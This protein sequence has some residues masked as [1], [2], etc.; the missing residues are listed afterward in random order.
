M[1]LARGTLRLGVF[2]PD[3]A[4]PTCKLVRLAPGVLALVVAY[5][6][7]PSSHT[8]AFKGISILLGVLLSIGSSSA[9][10][11]IVAGCTIT[12]RRAFREG[13]RVRI[14][15]VLGDV[16][17]VRL[18]VTHLRTPKHEEVTIPNAQILG[19][20][21]VNCG[22]LAKTRG[23]MVGVELGIGCEVPWR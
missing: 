17:K 10:A 9:I 11:N 3:W 5:P 12:C 6:D 18:Q 14:G 16:T 22:A 7:I 4:E 19:L 21:V 8:D 13:D 15:E 2:E 20:H 23:L 1:D